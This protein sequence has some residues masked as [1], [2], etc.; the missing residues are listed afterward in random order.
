MKTI[1]LDICDLMDVIGVPLGP[2]VGEVFRGSVFFPENG[3]KFRVLTDGATPQIIALVKGLA[4]KRPDIVLADVQQDVGEDMAERVHQL[5]YH[6]PGARRHRGE[7]PCE[8]CG[9]VDP[10]PF[11]L[12]RK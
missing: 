8:V 5:S 7:T 2:K 1:R 6:S 10:L 9:K 12:I 3:V 4:E 11:D